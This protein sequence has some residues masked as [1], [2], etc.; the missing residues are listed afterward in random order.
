MKM[1]NKIQQRLVSL[2]ISELNDVKI[3]QSNGL[4]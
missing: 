2:V 3:N 4:I 1:V